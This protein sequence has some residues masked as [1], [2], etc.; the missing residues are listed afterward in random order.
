MQQPQE[1][2]GNGFMTRVYVSFPYSSKEY[3]QRKH[4]QLQAK[5]YAMHLAMNNC[6]PISAAL[7]A[8]PEKPDHDSLLTL[9]QWNGLSR[10]L[11]SVC[12]EMHVVLVEGWDKSSGV[13]HEIEHAE[14]LQIP[15]KYFD[16]RSGAPVQVERPAIGTFYERNKFVKVV[17]EVTA[18]PV[19]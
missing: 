3:E 12:T 10:D 17:E 19:V 7:L 14:F 16:V 5:K 13:A 1:G 4:R 11:L 15:V 6:T 9:D 8:D 2:A 18:E